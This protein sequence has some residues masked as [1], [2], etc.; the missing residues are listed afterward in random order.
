MN[1]LVFYLLRS[2]KNIL[3]VFLYTDFASLILGSITPI[4]FLLW[5]FVLPICASLVII[6][7]VNLSALREFLL[8]IA[9]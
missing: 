1:K 3:R 8:I 4:S 9:F 2:Q 6:F 5:S 7:L